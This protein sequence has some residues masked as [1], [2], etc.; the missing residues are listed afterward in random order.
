MSSKDREMRERKQSDAE[1]AAVIAAL[2]A[3]HKKNSDSVDGEYRHN[4][5][6]VKPNGDSWKEMVA[7]ENEIVPEMGDRD[8]WRHAEQAKKL[9]KIKRGKA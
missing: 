4:C 9:K 3:A 6:Q 8:A 5:D 2:R 1:T 7:E